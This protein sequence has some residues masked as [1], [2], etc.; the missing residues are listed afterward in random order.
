MVRVK[1]AV[2]GG[3]AVGL[4]LAGW[5]LTRSVPAEA[6]G[7]DGFPGALQVCNTDEPGNRLV[8]VTIGPGFGFSVGGG[9]RCLGPGYASQ[10]SLDLILLSSGFDVPLG[11][12]VTGSPLDP[13]LCAQP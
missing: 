9:V 4:A 6:T 8:G 12:T 10:A 11:T 13:L 2:G 3:I 5:G 1:R 7:C